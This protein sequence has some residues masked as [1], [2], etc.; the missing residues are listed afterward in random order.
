MPETERSALS[1]V[2]VENRG[3]PLLHVSLGPEQHMPLTWQSSLP[4]ENPPVARYPFEPHPHNYSLRREKRTKLFTRVK[5]VPNHKKPEAKNLLYTFLLSEIILSLG[6]YNY[7]GTTRLGRMRKYN[8][9]IS[10]QTLTEIWQKSTW[11]ENT[12][13]PLFPLPLNPC[14]QRAVYQ[15]PHLR[16]LPTLLSQDDWAGP[17]SIQW[18]M[19]HSIQG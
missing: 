16:M 14:F 12:P 11:A 8:T 18:E 6:I 3:G 5:S 2:A 19:S 10:S 1:L 4:L 15:N 13:P 9:I 17:E 7:T